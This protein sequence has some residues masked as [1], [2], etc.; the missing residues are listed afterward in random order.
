MSLFHHCDRYNKIMS[1][2]INFC[3]FYFE[4][5]KILVYLDEVLKC[6]LS[7]KKKFFR[8]KMPLL[9]NVLYLA[10]QAFF[11]FCNN[12]GIYV[13]QQY[14]VGVFSRPDIIIY[15]LS[16]SLYFW[17]VQDIKKWQ[18]SQMTGLSH[19]MGIFWLKS[20]IHITKFG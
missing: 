5:S 8:N 18:I 7:F 14:P 19:E 1:S 15:Y 10:C 12:I 2:F 9:K 3:S 6:Y 4:F 17:Y 13:Q 16:K 20:F 11:F